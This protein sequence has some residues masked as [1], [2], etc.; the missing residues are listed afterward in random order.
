[1]P[2]CVRRITIALA[3]ILTAC[4]TVNIYF[5]AAAIQKAA[6][7]IV[8]DV[9]G[10]PAKEKPDNKEDANSSFLDGFR[11]LGIGPSNAYAQINIEVSTPAIRNLRQAM[12]DRFAALKPFY[13]K[14]SIGENNMGLL[15]IRDTSP[16][17]LKEKADVARLADQENRDRR[18]LY[19]E[20]V[21]ANSLKPESLP[22]VQKLF[23]NSWRG[24]SQ[25][26]WWIQNDSNGWEKKK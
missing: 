14:G 13:D 16:L 8:D 26:N 19:S 20:I 23:A 21:K 3:F 7:Q 1:M 18:A 4:V 25:P 10:T 5:P 17:N 22:Q 11:N 15:D 12:K 2:K 24:K 9:R 6:D